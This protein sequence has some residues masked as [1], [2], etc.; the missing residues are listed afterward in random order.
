MVRFE[1][2][3]KG[4][5]CWAE[6]IQH[7]NNFANNFF[8]VSNIG[9]TELEKNCLSLFWSTTTVSPRASDVVFVMRA[10]WPKGLADA[11]HSLFCVD[12]LHVMDKIYVQVKNHL[13]FLAKSRPIWCWTGPLLSRCSQR[14]GSVWWIATVLEETLIK[15]VIK[16]RRMSWYVPRNMRSI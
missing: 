3:R 13:I 12:E 6:K 16:S 4:N 7:G 1:G 15:Q 5:A 9:N 2:L 10:A 14:R 11:V 8:L